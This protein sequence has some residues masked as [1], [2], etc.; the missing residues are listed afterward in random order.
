MLS[1]SGTA[2]AQFW[3]SKVRESFP[4]VRGLSV[5]FELGGP[6]WDPR[7]YHSLTGW[8]HFA[9]RM[10]ASSSW[11]PANHALSCGFNER[12]LWSRS[13]SVG[14]GAAYWWEGAL[15]G[16]LSTKYIYVFV[17]IFKCMS[18]LNEWF[19][20]NFY[21]S[22]LVPRFMGM[23]TVCFYSPR[24]SRAQR[25]AWQSTG[26][27]SHSFWVRN[28][29]GQSVGPSLTACS[30]CTGVGADGKCLA[31]SLLHRKL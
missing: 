8:S 12:N 1:D 17:Y 11:Y 27:Q 28:N 26:S 6:M 25:A 13:S 15:T 18:F 4:D 14:V 10:P 5:G 29:T 3:S 22:Y 23:C 2:S 24:K 21:V 7:P 9:S 19:N 20:S 30:P 31:A 16:G